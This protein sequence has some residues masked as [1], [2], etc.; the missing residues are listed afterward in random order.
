[1][2]RTD[3]REYINEKSPHFSL[4][5]CSL[6]NTA[7]IPMPEPIHMLVTKMRFPVCFAI[8][9]PVA[10]W[11]APAVGKGGRMVKKALGRAQTGLKELTHSQRVANSNCTPVNIDFFVR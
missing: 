3:A 4:S 10:T 6:T 9:K 5:Q 8:F 11:R 7:A 2:S 1:M